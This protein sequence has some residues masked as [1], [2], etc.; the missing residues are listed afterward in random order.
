MLSGVYAYL[1]Q[2]RVVFGQPVAEAVAAECERLGAGRAFIVAARSLAAKTPVVDAIRAR[3]GRRFAGLFDACKA[4]SPWQSVLAAA[5]A[6]SAARPDILVS[7]GGGS[8][9]D[10]VKVLQ[11]CLAENARTPDDLA[12]L[13]IRLN[14]DGSRQVPAIRPSPVRQIAVPTTLSGAEFSNMG[15]AYDERTGV[16]EAFTGPDICARTVILDPAVTIY[17]PEWLW[18]STSVRSVDHAVE[19]ICAA[20]AQ[21]MTDALAL[22][23]LR[24]FSACLPRTRAQPQDLPARLDCLLAVWMAASTIQK[25]QFG[26]SHGIGHVLGGL[27]GVPHGHTSCILLPHVLRWNAPANAARQA[28]VAAALGRSGEPAADAVAALIAALGQPQRLRDAGVARDALP[29][30]AALAMDNMWVRANPRRIEGPADVMEILDA[31]Y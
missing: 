16:K 9:V 5:A 4:H 30:I 12:R 22:H 28:M 25:V 14:P 17:T 23:A 11:I 18:L 26:A 19:A 2:D 29:K 27:C 6:V 1:P 8:V 13:H 31:A 7:V 24:L 15:G 20:D 10:T 3:L 21:P